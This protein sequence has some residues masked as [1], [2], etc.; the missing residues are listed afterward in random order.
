MSAHEE[1]L[2]ADPLSRRRFF[3]ASAAALVAS[4]VAAAVANAGV[5]EAAAPTPHEALQLLREGNRRWVGGILEHPH[6]SIARRE[7]LRHGQ[8]PFATVF[9]C[10]DSRVPPEIVFDTGIGDLAVTRTGAQVLDEG[11]V[12][13]TIEFTAGHLHTPLILVM[14]HQRCGAVKAAIQT[15][16]SGGTAPG[17]IQAVVDAL[18]P[19]YHAALHKPGDQLDNTIRAQTK[20]T[21]ARLRHD[22]L[23]KELIDRGELAIAGAYYSLDT[24]LASLIA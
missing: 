8:H 6:Q 17:H 1:D 23:L 10:V 14:G 7:E 19:A 12:L 11:M 3:T 2:M 5:A 21:T 20:L 24:G 16:E 9:S 18:R 13:G 15:I 22:P 4:D